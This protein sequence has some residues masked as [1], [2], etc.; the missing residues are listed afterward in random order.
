MI[1][2]SYFKYSKTILRREYLLGESWEN[3]PYFNIHNSLLLPLVSSTLIS[4]M[5]CKWK[6]GVTPINSTL[7]D[8]KTKIATWQQTIHHKLYIILL[9][10]VLPPSENP[11]LSVVLDELIYIPDHCFG[12]DHVAFHPSS[13]L[14]SL[15]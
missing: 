3:I 7:Y 2:P 6:A 9:I 11:C 4:T 1:L 14:D 8:C 15:S 12:C 10:D 5:R 13:S